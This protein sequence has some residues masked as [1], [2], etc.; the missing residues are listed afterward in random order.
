MQKILKF[1]IIAYSLL[2][3]LVASS[4]KASDNNFI[5]P[6]NTK[7]IDNI[8][9]LPDTLLEISGI[10]EVDSTTIACI[11][12]ENG[13]IF[14]LD[15][16]SNKIISTFQ[17]HFDGDYEGIARINNTIY[18]LRSDG[19]LYEVTNFNMPDSKI[20]SYYTGIPVNNNEGLCYNHLTKNLLIGCKGKIGKGPAY[21][22]KRVIYSFDLKSKSLSKKPV[23]EFSLQEIKDYAKKNNI[24]VPL[25]IRKRKGEP[26]S[27]PFIKFMISA[28]CIHPITGDLY[29][30]SAKDHLLLIFNKDGKIEHIEQLNPKLFNK[31]EGITFLKNGDML[32]SNEGQDQKP[33]IVGL[34]YLK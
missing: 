30:L 34:K 3:S 26:Y 25:K 19:V 17:F 14:I 23:Y 27:E 5:F 12:D 2:I 31:P 20:F 7:V 15:L 29:L 9:V 1:R 10:T 21:K 28:I 4:C 8:W 6:Y 16:L 33:T 18:V 22:D 11:Q 32:I 24:D 13:I